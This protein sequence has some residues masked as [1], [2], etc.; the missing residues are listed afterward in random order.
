MV[1]QFLYIGTS[2]TVRPLP[3]WRSETLAIGAGGE[4]ESS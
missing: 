1:R 4:N 3:G 2:G